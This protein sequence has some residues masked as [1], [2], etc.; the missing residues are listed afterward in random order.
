M[1]IV[2]ATAN[3][4]CDKKVSSRSSVTRSEILLV[5]MNGTGSP[6][7]EKNGSNSLAE[8]ESDASQS[9]SMPTP[10]PASPQNGHE[11]AKIEP[12][13]ESV[14]LKLKRLSRHV[15]H[16]FFKCCTFTTLKNYTCCSFRN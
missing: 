9:S 10:V 2:S 12:K 6:C 1:R 4:S 16:N 5:D 14:S 3:N 11:E 13:I 15:I 8:E 7:S